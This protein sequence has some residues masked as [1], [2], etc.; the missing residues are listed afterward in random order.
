MHSQQQWIDF[1]Q[2]PKATA[3]L[4]RL[5]GDAAVS[6]QTERYLN[7]LD[8]FQQQF[9]DG[10]TALF[11]TPGRTEIS[12]N[13]TDHNHGRVLAASINLDAIAA[14]TPTENHCVTLISEGFEPFKVDLNALAA[15]PDEEGTTEALIRGIAAR[16]TDL[17]YTIGGFSAV[18][19]SDVLTGSGLSSSAAVEVLIASIFNGLYNRGK[20]KP[21]TLAR[22]GQYAENVYFGKPCGLMDQC[23]CAVGGIIAIDFA[24][25]EKPVIDE[26]DFDFNSL[27]YAL[28]VVDTGGDHADLTGDYAAIPQEMKA[29]A[30][31]FDESVCRPLDFAMLQSKMTELRQQA[32][33]RAVLRALHFID[34]N[35][36]VYDQTKAL[37]TGDF[38]EFLYLVHES[39]L[40]SHR[41]LQ[42]VAP[43][44]HTEIQPIGLALALAERFIEN[45]GEGAARV[46]GGGFAGTIQIFLPQEK[47]QE[48]IDFF[49]PAFGAQ[50]V[51]P[52]SIR[53]VGTF[54][55][56]MR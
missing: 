11:S 40:S 18:M 15:N 10:D 9:G 8:R 53:P 48:L 23:A 5:Y 52:L 30:A 25:P 22:I 31:L 43:V 42:N 2:S 26:I 54:Q 38:D 20:I 29:V 32:G 47:V 27:E 41:W 56:R 17:G 35:K 13:H 19:T 1:L 7:L 34:E 24:K 45:T 44:H 14:A 39:G 28:C 51:K 50:A 46:H 55:W 37:R 36:R 16:F 33:D 49:T 6:T 4:T 3:T 12:G 21:A